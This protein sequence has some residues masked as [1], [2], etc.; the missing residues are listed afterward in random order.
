MGNLRRTPHRTNRYIHRTYANDVFYKLDLQYK[1]T[2]LNITELLITGCA[3]DF[4]VA[5]SA[6]SALT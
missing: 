2:E 5:A 6:Q 4:C 1:R 3:T